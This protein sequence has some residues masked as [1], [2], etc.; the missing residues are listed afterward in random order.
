MFFKIRNGKRGEDARGGF[1]SAPSKTP[2]QWGYGEDSCILSTEKLAEGGML[3]L[4]SHL[5]RATIGALGGLS[6]PF[7]SEKDNGFFYREDQSELDQKYKAVGTIL[8][9]A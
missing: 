7:L 9:N 2:L 4:F 6:A 3:L 5:S 8:I 1:S